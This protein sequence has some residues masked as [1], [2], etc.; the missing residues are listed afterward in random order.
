MNQTLLPLIYLAHADDME[1]FLL[2]L[3][4][5]VAQAEKKK[6]EMIKT[7]NQ[8][9]PTTIKCYTRSTFMPSLTKLETSNEAFQGRGTKILGTLIR[10]LSSELFLD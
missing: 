2:P 9:V 3:S 4:H 1:L 5:V 7:H 8:K 10:K 6:M